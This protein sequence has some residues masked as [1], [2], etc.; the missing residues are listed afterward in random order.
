M[1]KLT[2]M[3]TLADQLHATAQRE[4]RAGTRSGAGI[5]LDYDVLAQ[6]E[7]KGQR[8]VLT[9]ANGLRLSGK[10]LFVTNQGFNGICVSIKVTSKGAHYGQVRQANIDSVRVWR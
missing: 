5:S 1:A 3:K 4:Y 2:E 7:F 10:I 6:R 8:A 9:F